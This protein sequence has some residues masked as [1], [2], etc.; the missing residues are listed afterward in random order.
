MWYYNNEEF[1]STPDEYQGF[2]YIITEISTDKKYIG[3]K[4]F[5]KPKTLPINKKRK[6]RVRTR[7][8]SDWREYYSSSH[9]VVALVEQNGVGNYRRDILKLCKTKGE[10]SYYEAKFQFEHDVLLREDYYNEFIGCKIHSKH[11]LKS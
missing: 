5:W 1:N 6:R 10:M 3:K 8:E 9:E 2:V 4:N 11:L 7:T